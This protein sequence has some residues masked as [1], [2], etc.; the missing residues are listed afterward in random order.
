MWWSLPQETTKELIGFSYPFFKYMPTAI[1]RI[2]AWVYCDKVG[3]WISWR[4]TLELSLDQL[5]PTQ[6]GS[7]KCP[8]DLPSFITWGISG[9]HSSSSYWPS[10]TALKFRWVKPSESESHKCPLTCQAVQ[11]GVF[12]GI[13]HSVND[14]VQQHLNSDGFRYFH[15]GKGIQLKVM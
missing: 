3:H 6:S 11:D 7:H 15:I 10:P 12:P 2:S 1:Q 8:P 14:Q 4:E 5:K 13:T 9:D